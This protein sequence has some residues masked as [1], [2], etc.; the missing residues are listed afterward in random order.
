MGR[1]GL[2][3][4]FGRWVLL[5]GA[6]AVV[7]TS[8]AGAAQSSGERAIDQAQRAVTER[9]VRG[10]GVSDLTVQFGSDVRTDAPSNTSVRVRG[11]G[12]VIRRDGQSRPFSYEATVNT[13]NNSVSDVRYDWRGNWYDS[14]GRQ[15]VT[16][17][18]TG[19]YR[20]NPAR[21]DN[22][23]TTADRVTRNLPARDQQRLRTAVTRR[24]EAPETLAIERDGRTI[25]LA[26]SR[27]RP[28]TFEADGREQTERSGN[29]R[30]IRTRA[31]LSG[32]RLVVS[33]E[34]DRAVDYQVTFE[35]IDSG[36]SL[37]VTRR[38][39]HEDLRQAV[40]AKSVYDKTSPT[41]QFDLYRGTREDDRSGGFRN[42]VGVP[43]GTELVAVLNGRLS[44]NQARDGDQFTMTVRSPSQYA[45]AV[46]TG[47]LVRVARSGQVAGRAEMS[48]AFDSISLRDRR[49]SPFGGDIESVRT[50]DGETVR[51]DNEGQVQEDTSQTARTVTRT[52]IGA[53]IGAVIGAVT[54]GGKGAAIGAAV[55]AGAG[56]G[57]VFIQGRD[58]LDLADGTEFRIRA[59]YGQ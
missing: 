20:L 24:L 5:A 15:P 1:T 9:I 56:A 55:G 23:D 7:A 30:D 16:N 43:D 49:V 17:R 41:P 52:G 38:I 35:S 45:G 12:N 18:L 46:I 22:P 36:R 11:T 25:T 47:H 33:T 6:I 4:S 2:S 34:G 57:S 31:T 51:V 14:R 3:T 40:V 27:A 19:T 37:R 42:D 29:G 13:R 50:P 8:A 44:T 59:R 53:A 48:F 39:T 10:E 32:D 21:S 26:S 54:G 58:D 28:V